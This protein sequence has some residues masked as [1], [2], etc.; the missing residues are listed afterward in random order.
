MNNHTT[1]SCLVIFS[2]SILL[3]DVTNTQAY[4]NRMYCQ[5]VSY[6]DTPDHIDHDDEIKA[7]VI[8]IRIGHALNINLVHSGIERMVSNTK[9]INE[10]NIMGLLNRP[11][12]SSSSRI[13]VNI[14]RY[15]TVFFLI[16]Y[17]RNP[18]SATQ[19]LFSYL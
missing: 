19:Q 11:L 7:Y 6:I 12:P 16:I 10:R 14:I 15:I 2:I 9:A 8:K 18:V 4:T 3:A 5:I 1:I 17:E 13:F